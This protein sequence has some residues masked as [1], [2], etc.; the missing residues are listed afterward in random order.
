MSQKSKNKQ[1]LGPY[2]PIIIETAKS[3]AWRNLS[4]GARSLYTQLRL[5]FFW[6]H[7]NHNNGRLWLSQ[8][9]AMKELGS[10]SNEIA[11]WYRELVFFGFIVQTRGAALGSHG[12][13][14]APHWRVTD[15]GYM[16]EPPTKDFLKWNGTPFKD[17]PQRRRPRQRTE[18]RNGKALRGVTEKHY[19][20]RKR[21]SVT[22]MG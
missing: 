18:S 16:H 10:S 22:P 20:V 5:R 2:A 19:V 3:E 15:I 13:G 11:K 7:G 17:T 9:D 6:N 21:I 1:Q 14:F 12:R 4:H 8:R